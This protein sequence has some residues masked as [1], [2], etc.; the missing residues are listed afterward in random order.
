MRY[1]GG[2]VGHRILWPLRNIMLA[3][4]HTRPK[5]QSRKG[6]EPV[7]QSEESEESDGGDEDGDLDQTVM[8]DADL[9]QED[10]DEDDEGPASEDEGG[11]AYEYDQDLAD[12]MSDYEYESKEVE[13][14]DIEE[15]EEFDQFA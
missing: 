8:Y 7:Q 10:P 5:H 11:P 15:E 3:V 1:R 12:E 2:S 14:G 13:C 4:G 6:K 9:M